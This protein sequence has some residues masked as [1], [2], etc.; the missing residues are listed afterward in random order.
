MGGQRLAESR[1]ET[2]LGPVLCVQACDQFPTSLK[3]AH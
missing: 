2:V 1:S 3:L